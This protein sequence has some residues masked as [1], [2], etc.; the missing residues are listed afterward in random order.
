MRFKAPLSN[1]LV[2]ILRYQIKSPNPNP[3]DHYNQARIRKQSIRLALLPKNRDGTW[4]L[5]SFEL[6]G[7]IIRAP[8]RPRTALLHL[9]MVITLTC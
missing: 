4:I 3:N 2:K 1:S 6:L 9:L 7:R 5:A 8:T